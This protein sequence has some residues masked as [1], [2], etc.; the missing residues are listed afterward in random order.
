MLMAAAWL[1]FLVRRSTKEFVSTFNPQNPLRLSRTKWSKGERST[2][3][4]QLCTFEV[5]CP[6]QE[7]DSLMVEQDSLMVEQD[8]PMVEQDSLMVEQDSLMVEQVSLMVEQVSL[9][10]EQDSLTVEQVSL[11][12][13]QDSLTVEQD[14]LTVEQDSLTVEQDSLTVETLR[15][16]QRECPS[17]VCLSK[18]R[19]RFAVI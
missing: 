3:I 14:S 15:A 13:E 10:V 17:Q 4:F 2:P 8:S 7:Q 18:L 12:V 11:T 6:L 9:T 16:P 1:R 5:G 19:E